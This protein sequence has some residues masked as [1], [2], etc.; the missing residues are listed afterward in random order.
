[1]GAACERIRD[2]MLW[3]PNNSRIRFPR[4]LLVRFMADERGEAVEFALL[5]LPFFALIFA[6]IQVSLAMFA[7][8]ALQT[9]VSKA[10]RQIMTGQIPM[11][12]TG[13][14][15]FRTALCANSAVLSCEKMMIQ[16][17]KFADFS[18]SNPGNA[19]SIDNDCF[20]VEE[21]EDVPSSCFTPGGP[22][23]VT[24]VRV[25]YKWPLGISLDNFAKG[26]T[27]VAVSAFHN[28]PYN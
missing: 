2:M 14:G 16:V 12:G 3:D 28:E 4:H 17:Q 26:T 24:L 10:S 8:Q 22:G 25:S 21:D 13:M 1:M 27:L 7:N 19:D 23:E 11:A 15:G 9:T 6:I 20:E 5:A 18:G